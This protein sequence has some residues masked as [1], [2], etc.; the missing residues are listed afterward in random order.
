ML[1]NKKI[2]IYIIVIVIAV[3]SIFIS[4]S[5]ASPSKL[6]LKGTI[7]T[8]SLKPIAIVKD[9]KTNRVNMYEVGENIGMAKILEVRR[10]EIVLQEGRAKYILTLP[11]GSVKQPD[12][13]IFDVA[14]KGGT[15]HI[16]R[17]WVNKAIL[18]APQLM[19][20]I[21]IMPHFAKGRPRGMRLSRIKEGSI[22]DKAGV[23]SGDVVKSING[24]TL[25]TPHQIF[26]AYK[27]LR[28]QRN[29][30]VDIV[31]DGKTAVL[32]YIVE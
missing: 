28:N 13:T 20:D 8:R 15:F 10:G 12:L 23:K 24:M 17:A 29:F 27:K 19:R 18:K 9:K 2:L 21:K 11:G 30:R 3:Y 26:Q 32:N 31:R 4:L 7:F 25:N 5:E 1:N 22:F 14:K 6:E 16:S